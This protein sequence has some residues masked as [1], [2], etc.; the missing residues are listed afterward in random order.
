M[1]DQ[2]L[3]RWRDQPGDMLGRA[4][5]GG[6][7]SVAGRTAAVRSRT[8]STDISRPRA[9]AR[10]DK[11]F[12]QRHTTASRRSST[13]SSCAA[14]SAGRAP[15]GCPCAAQQRPGQP[16]L[17]RRSPPI[18]AAARPVGGRPWDPWPPPSTGWTQSGRSAGCSLETSPTTRRVAAPPVRCPSQTRSA[19]STTRTGIQHPNQ[20]MWM[21]VIF[22]RDPVLDGLGSL[23]LVLEQRRID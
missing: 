14:T 1:L 20:M 16:Q 10:F 3:G 13:C 12:L 22:V 18:G 6:P 4:G 9:A 17:R 8:R 7:G 5:K 23:L 15:A 2:V 11:D 21:A 19:R